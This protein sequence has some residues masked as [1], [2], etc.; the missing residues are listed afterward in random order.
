MTMDATTATRGFQYK[1]GDRP[2]DGYTIQ[3]GGGPRR[4]RGSLLRRQRQRPR[5]RAQ[6]RADLRAD[7]AARHQPL[8]EPEEPAPGHRLRREVRRTTAGRGSSWNSSPGPSLRRIA[9]C[10]RPSGLG[11]QKAAFFLREIGKGLTYLHDCGIVHRDLKPGNIFYENGYVKI[12]DYGLSKAISTSQHSGQTVTVGTRAL[13]GAGDRRREATTSSIDI[14]ALGALLFEMLTGQVPFYGASPAEVLMK[15]LSSRGECGSRGGAVH[16]GDPQGDGQEPGG[17]IPEHSGDGGGGFRRRAHSQQRLAVFAGELDDGGGTRRGPRGGKCRKRRQCRGG[18]VRRQLDGRSGR[19]GLAGVAGPLA[20]DG[21]P[22]R[23]S[24]GAHRHP[25][26]A[27]GQAPGREGRALW[28]ADG[29]AGGT[30]GGVSCRRRGEAGFG[31]GIARPD[32]AGGPDFPGVR[33]NYPGGVCHPGERARPRS[34]ARK[35]RS[36]GCR[37]LAP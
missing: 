10:R 29:Q 6:G 1:H 2:L 21:R 9:R 19:R 3:R 37:L 30:D 34:A 28:R 8:H 4:V 25:H 22:L 32:S 18:C 27:H 31:R 17:S 20:A 14:Y 35:R 13:H 26:G 11:A 12:G 36:S 23:G 7:R 24:L 16:D 15:H 33:G 5:G